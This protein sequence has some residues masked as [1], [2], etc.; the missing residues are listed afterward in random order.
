MVWLVFLL[1]WNEK[2]INGPKPESG[3]T[4]SLLAE[5]VL[6]LEDAGDEQVFSGTTTLVVDSE[7][8][9]YVNDPR[10]WQVKVFDKSGNLVRKFGKKGSGPGEF[11]EPVAIA[12]GGDDLYIFDTGHKKM[13]VLTLDG[14][15]KREVRFPDAIQGVSQPVVLA[16]G[17]VAFSAFGSTEDVWTHS[18]GLYDSQLKAIKEIHRVG[19]G[20]LDFSQAGD[21]SFWVEVLKAQFE[22]AFG[23]MPVLAPVDGKHFFAG[24]THEYQG[25]LVGADGKTA[26]SMSREYKPGV[27]SEA[28]KDMI[29]ETIWQDMAEN[30]FLTPM[31]TQS[32]YKRA[33][34]QAELPPGILPM[35]AVSQFGKG[36]AV[37]TNYDAEKRKGQIDFFNESGQYT[38]AAPF[39]GACKSM[40]GAGDCL[41]IIGLNETDALTITRYRVGQ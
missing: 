1:L 33:R 3:K 38:A 7:G 15:Y 18:L 25:Q 40:Y 24:L 10:D 26:M 17:Q 13:I 34:S 4:V 9:M 28:A 22:T 23:G 2:T 19:L 41:Y 35:T 29:C 5:L 16:S 31:L 12:M 11:N 8:N 27:M 21:S 14:T 6:G 39:E 37:L 36:F 30:P 20:K 32:V